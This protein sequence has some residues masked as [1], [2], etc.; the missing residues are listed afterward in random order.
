MKNAKHMDKRLI[1]ILLIVFVQ[2]LGAAMIMPI[3][4]LYAQR[5]FNMSPQVITLLGTAFFAAQF[6]AGPYLGR[7]SD[8]MGRIPVLIIS[9]IGTAVSFLMLAF[10]PSVAFLF[11]ARI[12]DGITGGNIIVAQAYITDITPREKRT[13]ALGYVFATFGLGFIFGPALGGLLA[14]VFGPRVP[15][16]IAA[17]AAFVVVLLT[18]FTLDE[19]LTAVQREANRQ[20][21]KTSINPRAILI[22][23]HLMLILTIAFIGQ[24]GLGLLQ[25][26]F[27]LY[28]NAVLF[29]G[30]S[31]QMVNLGI[32]IL[33]MLVG[34]GQFTTQVFILPRLLKQFEEPWIV[35]AGLIIRS[36]GLFIFAALAMPLFGAVA[37]LCFAVGIGI[38]MPPLQSMSTTSVADELRGG[39]LGVYQSTISLSTIVSTA[40]AGVIFA[41]N[42]TWPFWIGGLLSVVVLLPAIILI[43]QT[44]A[45]LRRPAPVT[46]SVS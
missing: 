11:A 15:Y 10:A 6:I 26:T 14:A 32:G 12:L 33:L 1:T 24:F 13:V 2:M 38:M 40:I 46:T 7:L 23:H 9:Q 37:S 35:A 28:G 42:P 27:A 8:K 43:K 45:K 18:Y 41:L 16:V 31:E 22:N 3:L 25:A 39:V 21:R 30:Y 19:S 4:P 34:V 36:F 17:V 5:E 20:Y 29:A 44:G